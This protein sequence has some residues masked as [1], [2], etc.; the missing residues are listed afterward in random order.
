M[1]YQNYLDLRGRIK[2]ETEKALLISFSND[3]TV[4]VPKSTITSNFTSQLNITQNFIIAKWFVEKS[5]LIL[6]SKNVNVIGKSGSEDF[7][8]SRL[9]Q[10]GLAG[11][12]R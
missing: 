8:K 10:R 4:W 7:L 5:N 11:C 9:L 6:E 3:R 2:R 12:E 1:S